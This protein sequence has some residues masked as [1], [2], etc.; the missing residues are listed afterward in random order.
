MDGVAVVSMK[1]QGCAE[2]LQAVED[3][4]EG[5]VG[6]AIRLANANINPVTGLATDYLNH[7]NEAIMLLDMLSSCPDCIADFLDW[8]PKN[9]REHF[10]ASRF[11]DRDMAVAAYDA[12]DPTVRNCLDMLA[13]TMTA[14]LEATRT[15]MRPGLPEAT[16]RRLARQAVAALKPLVARAGAVIN[17]DAE[18]IAGDALAPQA[19]VDRLMRR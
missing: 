12:A 11:K 5:D 16:T 10:L 19:A 7:F 4:P 6:G 8:Q 1:D 17:G 15:A 9:Y 14:V 3:R 18:A 13:E 2:A